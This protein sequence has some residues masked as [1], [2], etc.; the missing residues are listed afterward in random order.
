MTAKEYL[1]RVRRQ[2]YVVKQ[3]EQEARD[4]HNDIITIRASSLSEKVSGSK[5]SDT[6]DKY[7]RLEPLLLTTLQTMT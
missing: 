1:N 2:Y 4:I 3:V 6:A 7:I 5:S